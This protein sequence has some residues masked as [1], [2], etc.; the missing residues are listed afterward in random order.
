MIRLWQMKYSN[1]PI[2]LRFVVK[3]ET[4]DEAIRIADEAVANLVRRT[5]YAI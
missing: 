3:A 1:G 5:T 4:Y 2:C